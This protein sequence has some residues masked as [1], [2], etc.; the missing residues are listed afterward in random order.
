MESSDSVSVSL[1]C[2]SGRCGRRSTGSWVWMVSGPSAPTLRPWS[3]S[4]RSQGTQRSASPK[5]KAAS[6]SSRRR[7]KSA[8]R[9]TCIRRCWKFLSEFA[10]L[11][12]LLFYDPES[13]FHNWIIKLRKESLNLSTCNLWMDF[14]AFALQIKTRNKQ[15][16]LLDKTWE[17]YI[18]KTSNYETFKVTALTSADEISKIK[19]SCNS[20]E[21]SVSWII[22]HSVL[23]E[24]KAARE[25]HMESTRP[26]SRNGD[27]TFHPSEVSHQ[28]ND[29]NYLNFEILWHQPTIFARCKSLDWL[30]NVLLNS[31]RASAK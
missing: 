3:P 11:F 10:K 23:Q 16:K 15:Q 30:G 19:F 29:Y 4:A 27:A 12:F 13:F 2:R 26:K 20:S 9:S 21:L 5:S 24:V 6:W 1:C 17:N 31:L 22:L 18:S 7:R 25:R 28:T 14:A 8:E